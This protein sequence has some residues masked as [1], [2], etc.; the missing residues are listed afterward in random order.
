MSFFAMRPYHK[1]IL[2]I[3]KQGPATVEEIV[4][5][6]GYSPDGL[7]GRISEARTKYGYNI[8]KINGKYTLLTKD[9]KNNTKH[10]LT[11][12][13]DHRLYNQRIRVDQLT[14]A[15]QMSKEEV[16]DCLVQL[17]HEDRVLQIGRNIVIIYKTT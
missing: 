8:K 13:E 15:L 6:T 3:L 2:G 16:E 17:F 11:Y 7:R 5:L 9:S 12:L 10:L 1:K 14:L 4:E